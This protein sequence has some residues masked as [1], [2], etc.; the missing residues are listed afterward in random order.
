MITNSSV[1]SIFCIV[2][3]VGRIMTQSDRLKL[4]QCTAVNCVFCH[5]V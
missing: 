2:N 4:K 3:Y 1:C 5:C